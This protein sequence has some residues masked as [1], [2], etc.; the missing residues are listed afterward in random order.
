MTELSETEIV[1][2]CSDLAFLL[3]LAKITNYVTKVY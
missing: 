3:A 2:S 1:L